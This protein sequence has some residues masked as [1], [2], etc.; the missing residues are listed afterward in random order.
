MAT[1]G[2]GGGSGGTGGGAGGMSQQNLNQIVSVVTEKVKIV[3][4]S[5]VTTPIAVVADFPLPT[6]HFPLL[7][8]A[9]K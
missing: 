8:E 9:L 7:F 4:T 6:S 3:S 2:G 1:S 5:V